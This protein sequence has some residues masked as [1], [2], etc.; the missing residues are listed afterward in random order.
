MKNYIKSLKII[1]VLCFQLISAE[2]FS[3]CPVSNFT[4]NSPVCSGSPLIFS[5]NSSGATSYNWDF[6]PGFFSSPASKLTDTLLNLSFP[7]I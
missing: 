7:G 3:Q 1:I 4:V 2:N 6:T 5:N